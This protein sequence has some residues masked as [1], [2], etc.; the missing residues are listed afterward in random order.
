MSLMESSLENVPDRHAPD[1]RIANAR[2]WPYRPSRS[3]L[4]LA[5]LFQILTGCGVFFAVMRFS[6]LIAILGTIVVVPAVIRT[7]IAADLHRQNGFEFDW[8][9]RLS[10]FAHSLGMV[11]LTGGFGAA[12]FLIV[13]CVFG[14]LGLAFGFMMSYGDL[15]LDAAVVGAAGGM[16]WGMAGAL[17]AVFYSVLKTWMPTISNRAKRVAIQNRA[18]CPFDGATVSVAE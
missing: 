16:I 12:V 17:L 9:L 7:A 5:G 10:T 11:F 1:E 2:P 15:S 14:F 13:C 6:P 3:S 4:T 18:A 8:R